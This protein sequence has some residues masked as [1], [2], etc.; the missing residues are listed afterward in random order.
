MTFR[1][2][3]SDGSR[4][5]KKSIIQSHLGELFIAEVQAKDA[6]GI[7]VKSLLSIPYKNSLEKESPKTLGDHAG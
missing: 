7:K 1:L 5:V 6:T 3:R 4:N 2:R